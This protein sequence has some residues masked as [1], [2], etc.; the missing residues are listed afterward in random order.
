ML[1]VITQMNKNNNIKWQELEREDKHYKD[2]KYS[3]KD[4]PKRPYKRDRKPVGWDGDPD[5][6]EGPYYGEPYDEDD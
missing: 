2:E 1:N 5:Y 6:E 4:K 3:N